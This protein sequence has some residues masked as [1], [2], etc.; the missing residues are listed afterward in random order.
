MHMKIAR[1]VVLFN[2][3]ALAVL[4]LAP[5]SSEG[6]WLDRMFNP[7]LRVPVSHAP[8]LGLQINKVA[9]GGASGE[10]AAEFI[11]ALTSRF[12]TASVEVIR[13]S[14]RRSART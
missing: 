1:P 9:F 4:T 12:V 3:I 10:G 8:G 14:Q 13:Y 7:K 6:Q 2:A 5:S 11:D